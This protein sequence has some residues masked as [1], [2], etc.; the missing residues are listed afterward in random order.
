MAPVRKEE[1]DGRASGPREGLRPDPDF[2]GEFAALRA[3]EWRWSSRRFRS[4]TSRSLRWRSRG[5]SSEL[6]Y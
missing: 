5:S 6:S 1:P 2:G 4:S 3:E